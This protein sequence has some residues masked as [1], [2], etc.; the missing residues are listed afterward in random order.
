MPVNMELAAKLSAF[1]K[2]MLDNIRMIY[3][4]K[5]I[6]P[7]KKPLLFSVPGLLILYGVVYVP[8]GDKV[9]TRA[10]ELESRQLIASNYTE[11]E[12]AKTKLASYQHRLPLIKDKEEWLNY[13]MTSTAKIYGIAFDSLSAQTENEIGSFL[14]VTRE[15][16]VTTTYDKFGRWMAEIEKSPIVLRVADATIKKE[17]GR[18]GF[19]KATLKL[20]TIFPR[21]GVSEGGK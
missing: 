4:E 12:D 8:L 15:V 19:I 16:S 5:G 9:R 2:D 17:E 10:L 14:L 3:A 13:L 7:F 20:S 6:E 21:F 18:V 11:Y 1:L